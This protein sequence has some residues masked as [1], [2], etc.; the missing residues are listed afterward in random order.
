MSVREDIATD[1]VTKLSSITSP[2]IVLVTRNPFTVGSLAST[3]FPAVFV[4]TTDEDRQDF[5]Q[6]GLRE[7]IIEYE[8]VASVTADSS[9]TSTNNN[10]DTKR[11]EIIEAICEKLEED[12][13]R[14]SKALHSEITRVQVDD[15]T[16]FPIGQATI[17]YSVQY[18]YT[19]GTN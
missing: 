6:A 18:K 3:Q 13:T 7:G 14:N 9:A 1:I 11:N 10:I 12:T 15:G 17:T 8:I 16:A 2:N 5:T 19:R 4:R